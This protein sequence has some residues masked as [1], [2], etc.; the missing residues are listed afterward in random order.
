M[1]IEE[2]Y[3]I[4]LIEEE[5]N[6]LIEELPN[7]EDQRKDLLQKIRAFNKA[8][9]RLAP[10]MQKITGDSHRPGYKIAG[11]VN[12]RAWHDLTQF[13]KNAAKEIIGDYTV[14]KAGAGA[15]AVGFGKTAGKKFGERVLAP[16]SA[17]M[18]LYKLGKT[19][20]TAITDPQKLIQQGEHVARAYT[21]LK[22]HSIQ[23]G[24][25]ETNLKNM[26]TDLLYRKYV[27]LYRDAY[28]EPMSKRQIVLAKR[29]A[30]MGDKGR[31]RFIRIIPKYLEI[32]KERIAKLRKKFEQAHRI[33][34]VKHKKV[35]AKQPRKG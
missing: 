7:S 13:K 2:H 23:V 18:A 29:L 12:S 14:D 24:D 8:D 20:N 28:D 25:I 33:L 9:P 19:I 15:V 10:A 16:V 35:L 26:D 30:K 32:K 5:I 3:L 22:R 11:S 6:L 1:K 34:V 27:S 17:F 4:Q 21:D 31:E